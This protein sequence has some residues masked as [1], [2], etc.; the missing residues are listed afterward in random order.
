M[1]I[2][3]GLG[4]KMR[5]VSGQA[6]P[7]A[8][9]VISIQS[10]SGYAGSV[11]RTTVAGQWYAD[12]VA[13]SGATGVQWT[14]TLAYEGAVIRCGASNTIQMWLPS[15]LSAALKTDGAWLD[16]RRGQTVVAGRVTA[17]K[18]QFGQRDFSQSTTTNQPASETIA[19]YPA[20]VWSETANNCGL[21]PAQAFR[22]AWCAAVVRCG[23]GI[24]I[25]R[26]NTV[27]L[28]SAG[29]AKSAISVA[30]GSIELLGN[31]LS[32]FTDLR[33]DGAAGT[34]TQFLPRP[35]SIVSMQ[36]ALDQARQWG[37]GNS[38]SNNGWSGPVF[39]WLYLGAVPDAD[40][41][42]RIEGCLAHRNGVADVLSDSHTYRTLGPRV[43]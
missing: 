43:Q 8:G 38:V 30:T 41:L 42:A 15:H 13:I 11:Y 24:T 16:P 5:R 7:A 34:A 6:P 37:I 10:G 25:Q 4:L 14:M 33:L 28:L 40:T 12:D 39:E 36:L 3:I 2:G 32:S 35:K 1:G 9:P 17:L 26:G 20:V 29:I 27:S 21:Q 22:P 19:G 18:D 23:D 31:A